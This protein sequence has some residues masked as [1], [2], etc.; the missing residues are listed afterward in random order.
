LRKTWKDGLELAE[1]QE[2]EEEVEDEENEEEEEYSRLLKNEF[3][4]DKS[5][6]FS[7]EFDSDKKLSSFE[8]DQL[9][10]KEQIE[11]LE[12]DLVAK[13]DWTLAGEVNSKQRPKNSLL[14]QDLDVEIAS[15][16][17]PVITEET[18][19]TLEQI[20]IQRIKDQ[21][22]DDVV[23]KAPPKDSVYDPNRRWELD[24]E[25]SKKTLAEIYEDEYKKSQGNVV[26]SQNEI[27]LDKKHQEINSLMT[28]LC[29]Q[30]DA[31]SNWHY[32]PKSASLE[33]TVIPAPNVPAISMEEMIPISV[34]NADLAL[35]QEV[36]KGKIRKSEQELDSI[37]KKRNLR[38]SK[39]RAGLEKHQHETVK[40]QKLAESNTQEIITKQKAVKELMKQKNVTLVVNSKNQVGKSKATVV[41]KGGKIGK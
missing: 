22:F 1:S 9:K 31:L 7:D 34:S 25:K 29:Q 14:E 12:K 3:A 33:L 11:G 23:R 37:D 30:L 20:I 26:K 2:I 24:D 28:D 6:L 10:M 40:K 19:A 32:T 27:E 41:E 8:K 35:P 38:K 13:K 5:N 15:K 39:R 16:P 17:A 21:T 4:N 36:F 18:T